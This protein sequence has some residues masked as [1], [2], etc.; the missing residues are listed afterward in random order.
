MPSWQSH[1]SKVQSM[2]SSGAPLPIDSMAEEPWWRTGLV[3]TET[4]PDARQD[5]Y[6]SELSALASGSLATLQRHR[7]ILDRACSVKCAGGTAPTSS[8]T[9]TATRA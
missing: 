7:F 4:K 5:A 1:A 9:M 6:S 3:R 8:S 2:P